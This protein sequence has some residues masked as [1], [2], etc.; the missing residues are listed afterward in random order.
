[1]YLFKDVYIL[2]PTDS[3]SFDFFR[4][5]LLVEGKSILKIFNGQLPES[6]EISGDCE[7]V[8][9]KGTLMIFPGF[10]QTH[11]HLCQTLYR[12][13]AENMALL[14]WL[15][16]HIWPYEAKL[17]KKTIGQSVILSLKE[18]LSS[19]T[20]AVLDMGTVR[21]TDVIFEIMEI[22]GF[23]YTGGKAMMDAGEGVPADLA[24]KTDDSIN[25]SV[26]L[27]EKFHNKN[28]GML[29]YCFAPRFVLSC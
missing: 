26:R 4:G 13:R 28:N 10:I 21:H 29:K 15:K 11:I 7:V 12:N 18:I 24:E 20:T 23:R 9:G 6:F 3:E 17:T 14:P 27:Y 1:M 22:I 16:E 8:E 5:S 2:N 19:G 25:E